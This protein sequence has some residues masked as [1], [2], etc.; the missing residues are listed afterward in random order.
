[1]TKH[2]VIYLLNRLRNG[3]EVV[4]IAIDTAIKAVEITTSKRPDVETVRE[5]WGYQAYITCP[6]CGEDL[7]DDEPYCHECGQALDWSEAVYDLDWEAEQRG[8][9]R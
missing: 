9:T 2:N 5:E 6:N 7:T 8:W 1:M 4:D 3:E